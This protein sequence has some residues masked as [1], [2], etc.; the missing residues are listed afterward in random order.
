[1]GNLHS[2]LFSLGLYALG[3]AS[4]RTI[5]AVVHLYL[6]QLPPRAPHVLHNLP[7]LESMSQLNP[8]YDDGR[9]IHYTMAI[10]TPVQPLV[11]C[12]SSPILLPIILGL[13]SCWDAS[14][15]SS[16]CLLSLSVEL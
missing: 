2:F 16:H 7:A 9:T 11:K 13:G 12:F 8:R 4:H 15:H 14:Q 10:I 3:R 6:P 5:R 1:M